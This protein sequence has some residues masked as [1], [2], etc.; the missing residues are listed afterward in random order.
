[1]I[2]SFNL[3]NQ[4]YISF[5]QTQVELKT[6]LE[7]V[8]ISIKEQ[9]RG[10]LV[11]NIN[12]SV[13]KFLVDK[14][15]NIYNLKCLNNDQ[16]LAQDNDI[17]FFLI[18]IKYHVITTLINAN[19]QFLWIHAGAVSK[20]EKAIIFPASGGAGKSSFVYYLVQKGWQYLSDDVVAI[21]LQQNKI[22]PV[23]Q[24]PRIRHN[25]VNLVSE[26]NLVTI[27]KKVM[28][29]PEKS[30]CYH[31]LSIYGIIFPN[32]VKQEKLLF[33]ICS[34]SQTLRELLVNCINFPQHRSI[35]M[36]FLVNLVKQIKSLEIKYYNRNSVYP[37][38][39]NKIQEL[40]LK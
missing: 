13:A 24:T 5:A 16:I 8:L 27:P 35:A 25:I 26:E 30:Y 1:M 29:I 18:K 33:Q 39:E 7:E 20:E 32:F 19:S 4:L 9:F 12:E 23:P 3:K 14:K 22:L 34:E 15:D 31:A 2:E 37:L 17:D 11:E 38:L 10:M 21:D 36:K 28:I 6:N 40:I